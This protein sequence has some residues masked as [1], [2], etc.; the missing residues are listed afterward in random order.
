MKH[1]YQI[2]SNN[3]TAI[4]KVCG[5]TR[6]RDLIDYGDCSVPDK[7]KIAALEQRCKELEA[8]SREQQEM[9]AFYESI[10]DSRNMDIKIL[11]EERTNANSKEVQDTSTHKH[12]I[13]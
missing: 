3:I 12:P 13:P 4:C 2:Q 8:Q 9:I 11:Q 1:Y 6:D 10:I 7:E 5:D